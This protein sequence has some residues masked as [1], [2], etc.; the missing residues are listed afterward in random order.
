MSGRVCSQCL[1]EKDASHFT[2]RADQNYR[3]L[4]SRCHECRKANYKENPHRTRQRSRDYYYAHRDEVGAKG[5]EK[6]RSNPARELVQ[7]ARRRARLLGLPFDLT[8]ADVAIPSSCPVLGIPLAV[9]SGVC[10]PNSPT[11]DRVVCSGGYVRGNVLVVS[12]RA[13]TIKSDA[14]IDELRAVLAFYETAT[15]ARAA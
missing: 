5:K 9:N 8:E 3:R 11:L 12:F 14:T 2:W 13:N 15:A 1:T 4:T 10:G 6:R 7:G